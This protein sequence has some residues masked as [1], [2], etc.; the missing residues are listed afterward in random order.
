VSGGSG[1]LFR[2]AMGG[3]MELRAQL[4]EAD[5]LRTHVGSTAQVTPTGSAQVFSGT[6]WQVSPVIDPNTRQ[7]IARIQL[8]YD[9]ALRPGGFASTQI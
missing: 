5:L 9:P 4:A 8:S 1:V 2:M 6:V 7:G 3:Q